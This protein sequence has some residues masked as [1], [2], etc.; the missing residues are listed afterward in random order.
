[1]CTMFPLS[2]LST[3]AIFKTI[4]TAFAKRRALVSRGLL[5]YT[6]SNAVCAKE[7]TRLSSHVS[8]PPKLFARRCSAVTAL[9]MFI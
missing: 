9:V 8:E 2:F 5:C 1:M 7:A 4:Q 6:S 3:N